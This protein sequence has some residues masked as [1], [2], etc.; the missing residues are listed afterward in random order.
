MR[1]LL[2][3]D[4][5][6]F[7]EVATRML[8]ERPW[9]RGS[10]VRVLSVVQEVFPV[11]PPASVGVPLV[12]EAPINYEEVVQPRIEEAERLVSRTA[13]ELRATELGVE[14]S[15]RRGDPR[16]EVVHEAEEWHADLI[17]LGSHGRTGVER[18]LMGS[19]SEGVMR[20][21]PCSVEVV[22]APRAREES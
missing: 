14:T 5:S 3:I 9:P 19:V 6:E 1:I 7:S 12:T 2:A 21:A 20:H 15:T 17:V 8:T 22:R 10:V 16:K 18:L 11:A 13:E 4:G